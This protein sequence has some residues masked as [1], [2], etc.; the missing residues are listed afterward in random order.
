MELKVKAQIMDKESFERA[1]VRISHQ[2]I[3]KNHGVE[4]VCLIG[5]R[6]RG[7]PL[8]YRLAENIKKIEGADVPVG[9]L[10]IT[11]HRD[12]LDHS[13]KTIDTGGTSIPFSIKDKTVVLIDDV[14]YTCRT[15][16]AAMDAVMTLGRP[17]KIQFF[18]MIDRGHAELPIKPNYV[19]KSI[20]TSKSEIVSVK[21]EELDGITNITILEQI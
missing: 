18:A 20:P 9:E 6:T 7:V 4:N 1:L 8:A 12:D 21:L 19:G 15:A 13:E 17:A 3:E 11:M 2:I 14:I 10:D 5:I 16:R